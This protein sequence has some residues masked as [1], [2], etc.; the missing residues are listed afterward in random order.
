MNFK[1]IHIGLLLK[2]KVAESG[3]E[4]S[5]ICKFLKCNENEVEN[6]Y[7]VK[8]LDSDILLRWSKIL[9][10]D[11]FRV[12]S[13]HLILYAPPL[14]VGYK[15]KSESSKLPQFRKNVYTKEVIDF[16]LERIWKGEMTK[17]QVIEE[18]K[19]P[20]TTLYKWIDKYGTRNSQ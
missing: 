12:Y 14:S 19:I 2:I 1:K 18:Y 7:K 8:S 20:R 3:I 9:E 17:S 11:F 10:Y 4:L 16:I 15:S 13:Q 5:R 6:M